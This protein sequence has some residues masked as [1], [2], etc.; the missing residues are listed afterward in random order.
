MFCKIHLY[1]HCACAI[2]RNQSSIPKLFRK[3]KLL[4]FR[5]RSCPSISCSG[6]TMVT[7]FG[8]ETHSD[9]VSCMLGCLEGPG[10]ALPSSRCADWSSRLGDEKRWMVQQF[11]SFCHIFWGLPTPPKGRVLTSYELFV[12]H[13]GSPSGSCLLGC[14]FV[15]R[16]SR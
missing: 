13:S 16:A 5:I 3:T 2:Q 12:C 7:R 8:F 1:D 4:R 11:Q 6:L 9:V 10:V 14:V 15:L